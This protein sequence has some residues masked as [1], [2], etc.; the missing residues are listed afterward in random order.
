LNYLLLNN[1]IKSI[2]S[3]PEP[4]CNNWDY[5]TWEGLTNRRWSS[6]HLPPKPQNDLP[7]AVTVARDLFGRKGN[8]FRASRK[9]TLVFPYFAQWFVDGFLVGDGVDR[10]RNHSNHHI[11]LSQLYGLHPEVTELIRAKKGGLLKSQEIDG[12]GEVAPFLFDADGRMKPDYSVRR[13]GYAGFV[14][15]ANC[16]LHVEKEEGEVSPEVP[17][18][19]LRY[20]YVLPDGTAM[21][22]HLIF[23]EIPR[24]ERLFEWEG[25]PAKVKH[26]FA[27]ANDRGNSTPAFTMMST[28]ML[29][30][31]NRIARQLDKVYGWDDERVFQ[32]T[33]NILIVILLKLVIE[34]YINH[35]A[36]YHFKFFVDPKTLFK[37]HA[38]KW[39]NWMTTE[40]QLLYRWHSMIPDELALG[41]RTIR[42]SDSLWNPGLLIDVGLASM[43]QYASNQP[44]GEIGSKNTWEWLIDNA[45]VPSIQMGRISRLAPYND[46][47]EL[48]QMPRVT[49]FDQ[50][51]GDDDVAQALAHHYGSVDKIEY[52]TGIFCEDVRE[53]SALAPLIG[54]MVGADA[55]SQALPNPLLQSRTWNKDTFSRR[56]WE[57][58]HEE[59]HT[60]EALLKRN[61]PELSGDVRDKLSIS[62]TRK[63][64]RRT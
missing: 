10:R 27:F 39:Q 13:N 47:R 49:A 48:C 32:T 11:D 2:P 57:I 12:I 64:W 34:E 9:S 35:I 8:G 54:I 4:L 45:D 23:N 61:T 24:R 52:Y 55:F 15:I 14:D 16:Q 30:E 20:A 31:H 1:A 22:R 42:S 62:M 53:N 19:A 51:T 17:M 41:S 7:D 38:W 50:I 44:A 40:F 3:R 33:R 58:I 59:K 18:R 28:L 37:P 25:D 6:R 21:P 46:Y 63:D 60:I 29:R 36:P 56:G 43:F 26:V 5:T